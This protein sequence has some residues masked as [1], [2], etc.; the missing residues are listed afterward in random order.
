MKK[1]LILIFLFL[2]QLVPA[3]QID[4]SGIIIDS[5]TNK[6]IP[7]STVELMKKKLGVAANYQ[8]K[9]LIQ[10]PNDCIND[11]LIICSL[12]YETA[13]IVVKSLKSNFSNVSIL[14]DPIVYSLKEV[15]IIGIPA[16]RYR[17]GNYEDTKKGYGGWMTDQKSQISVFMDCKKYRNARIVNASFFISKKIGK[18]ETPFRV[19]VYNVDPKSG[20]PGDDLI[21]ESIITHGNRNGGWLTVDLSKYNLKAPADGYFIAIEWIDSG[22]QYYYQTYINPLGKYVTNYGPMLSSSK[23]IK[24]NNT[25]LKFLGQG[26]NIWTGKEYYNSLIISEIEVLK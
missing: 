24:T 9:F 23:T 22:E 14:L 2:R 6:I 1:Y 13:H 7:F 16:G 18:P 11:T 3:Q 5:K 15:E 12:G 25:W 20:N 10:L 8:G 19:R 26:W 17:L 21:H 4:V